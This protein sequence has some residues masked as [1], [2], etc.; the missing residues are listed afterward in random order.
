MA[1]CE[2]VTSILLQS[3]KPIS[4]CFQLNAKNANLGECHMKAFL[5]FSLIFFLR[6]ITVSNSL[7]LIK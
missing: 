1:G 5:Y 2:S 3:A 7:T 6:K 4:T